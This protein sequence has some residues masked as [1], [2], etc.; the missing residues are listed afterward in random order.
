MRKLG[1]AAIATLVRKHIGAQ[2][3]SCFGDFLGRWSAHHESSC[4]S[5]IG[6]TQQQKNYVK[7]SI[8][9]G[10][11]GKRVKEEQRRSIAGGD[12][13][14]YNMAPTARVTKLRKTLAAKQKAKQRVEAA[15]RLASFASAKKIWSQRGLVDST[16]LPKSY[17]KVDNVTLADILIVP[18]L[19]R[20]GQL[21]NG[22]SEITDNCT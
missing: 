12:D 17:K 4:I 3:R 19:S 5:K 8:E 14:V 16:T 2:T 18:C 11:L 15:A 13:E 21:V 9:K 7:N 10:N 22:D 20:I 1:F 6:W